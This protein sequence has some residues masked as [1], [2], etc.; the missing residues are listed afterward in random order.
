[1]MDATLGARMLEIMGLRKISQ[2]ELS[3]RTGLTEA[4]ISRYVNDLREPRAVTLAK[5]AEVLET[6]PDYLLDLHTDS[7]T[8]EVNEV[9]QLVARKAPEMSTEQKTLLM[10]L[11]LEKM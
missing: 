7:D 11:I 5:I 10:Q 2:R 3:Q 1:M 6:S 8:T 4:A 9:F